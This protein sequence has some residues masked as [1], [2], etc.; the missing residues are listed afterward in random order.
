MLGVKTG[1]QTKS[2]TRT[3]KKKNTVKYGTNGWIYCISIEPETEDEEGAWRAAMPSEY[4]AVTRICKPRQFARAVT[5]M[6]AEQIGPQG[7]T[8][9]NNSRFGEHA[10]KT[11]HRQQTVFHGPVLYVEDPYARIK[12]ARSNGEL[13]LLFL[14]LKHAAHSAERE[15][16][17]AVWAEQEPTEAFA[18]LQ[19]SADL[20]D[21]TTGRRR[22]ALYI[23][24][25]QKGLAGRTLDAP[26]EEA[27]L[28]SEAQESLALKAVQDPKVAVGLYPYTVQDLPG[29]AAEVVSTYAAA[30]AL[31]QAVVRAGRR[32][33]RAV[34]S[35][36]WHAEPIVR[37][38]CE[39]F[40]DGISTFRV[41]E[42]DFVV[43]TAEFEKSQARVEIAVGPEGSCTCRI[44]DSKVDSRS[45][46]DD[47][48]SF[49]RTL[50]RRLT[51]FNIDRR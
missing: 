15:Y 29:E 1:I 43:I 13:L 27:G 35:A 8:V 48:L 18:D 20:L 4:D 50:E 5:G 45:R 34:A 28:E 46:T 33:R 51:D 25:S 6:V 3:S 44:R 23:S 37:F 10:M 7:R 14:F 9:E 39:A 19:P 12:R 36:A 24:G 32:R 30:V 26:N 31:R 47:A 49:V 21:A 42:E 2:V 17:F 11:T 38:L 16:R 22:T 40:E 41:T